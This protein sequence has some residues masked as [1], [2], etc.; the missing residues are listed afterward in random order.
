MPQGTVKGQMEWIVCGLARV[1]L[2]CLT[3]LLANGIIL[4]ILL[5]KTANFF[6]PTLCFTFILLPSEMTPAGLPPLSPCDTI[7]T[8]VLPSVSLEFL[9]L[10]LFIHFAVDVM[11]SHSC[12]QAI[13]DT[14]TAQIP[15]TCNVQRYHACSSLITEHD[16]GSV[17]C[18]L[19][20]FSLCNFKLNQ[21]QAQLLCRRLKVLGRPSC[22]TS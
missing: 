15:S 21:P 1:L 4:Y 11:L 12:S 10:F 20:H 3:L 7:A 9:C 14:C 8:S 6:T 19:A 2:D 18:E 22:S 17:Y 5:T 13:P 16:D